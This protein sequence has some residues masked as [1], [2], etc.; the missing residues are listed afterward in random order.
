MEDDI[1]DLAAKVSEAFKARSKRFHFASLL[2]KAALVSGGAALAG[3][4]QFVSWK[5]DEPPTTWQIV[6]ILATIVVF[7]G[8]LFV[9]FTESD[10]SEE[11][12]LSQAAVQRAQ[13]ALREV[14]VILE[15][16][17][18][19]ERVIELYQAASILGEMIESS[20][21]AAVGDDTKIAFDMMQL[22]GRSLAIACGF[23]QNDRWTICIYKVVKDTA[24]GEENLVCVG[25]KR[26]LDCDITSARK[27]PMGE[28]VAGLTAYTKRKQIIPDLHAPELQNLLGAH[29][30][31]RDGDGER[32]KSM[33]AFPI[34]PL[35][36]GQ[37]WGVATATNDREG[38][39]NHVDEA[40]IKYEEAI[41]MLAQHMGLALSVRAAHMRSMSSTAPV[42]AP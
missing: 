17:A 32:Y 6:G 42:P 30:L 28:G 10:A 39:F 13:E 7:V 2:V 41:R 4:A 24:T 36:T 12:A 14:E 27:W 9:V 19:G 35:G 21:L 31:S 8:G 34:I 38:H 37:L 22:A 26:A 29:G 5:P 16:E 18:E 33:A 1:R 11:L 25:H 23:A 3:V 40:Q 15:I 20:T